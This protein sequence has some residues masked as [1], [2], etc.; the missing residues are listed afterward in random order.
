[1]ALAIPRN[2]QP[3]I[4]FMSKSAITVSL[5]EEARGGPFVFWDGLQDAFARGAAMGFDAVEIF[6]PGPDAVD[7]NELQQ[8]VNSTGLHV[9]AVGTGAGMVKHGLS[10]TDSDAGRRAAARDFIA[11]MIDFGGEFSAPAIIGSMQGRYGDEVSHDRALEYLAESV[12]VLAE[13]AASLGVPL[14]YEPLNRYETNLVNTVGDGV[15]FLDRLSSDNVKLLA[16]LFHMNIE[17]ANVA[18][19]IVAG[20]K[21]IGHVHLVDSNRRAAGL[22]HMDYSPIASALR[23]I[24]YDGYLCAEAFPLPDSQTAAEKTMDTVQ[25]FFA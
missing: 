5:V 16:D 3:N 18:E 1:M 9:A 22:G 13:H 11:S 4:D 15:A 20:A 2:F 6:A 23:A 17:E 7:R 24:D 25:R 14:I 12:E 21:H 10:L 19:A 8:L